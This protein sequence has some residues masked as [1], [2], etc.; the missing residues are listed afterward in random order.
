MGSNT[1]FTDLINNYQNNSSS[2]INGDYSTSGVTPLNASMASDFLS[3]YTDMI[4]A[5]TNAAICDA[6]CQ[7]DASLSALYKAMEEAR[8]NEIKA[9]YEYERAEEAYYAFLGESMPNKYQEKYNVLMEQ[10]KIQFGETFYRN[11]QL[12]DNYNTMYINTYNSYELFLDIFNTNEALK[13]KFNI[14]A[15]NIFTN[16]RKTMYENQGL[17]TVQFHG[18]ILLI[19]HIL[20]VLFFIFAVFYFK[21]TL[22]IYSK[23]GL[24]ILVILQPLIA[25]L[26]MFL[27]NKIY[28]SVKQLLPK[29]VYLTL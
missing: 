13:E 21:T 10:Y 29:N 6:S 20:F 23:I 4:T 1:P 18:K 27:A 9:P 26:M 7:Y 25:R 14:T 15:S 5:Q 24:I 16:D 19:F 2:V 17:K 11:K 22:S 28:N 12:N 3:K 8:L